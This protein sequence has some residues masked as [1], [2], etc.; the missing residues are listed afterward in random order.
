MENLR[1]VED[2]LREDNINVIHC[3]VP[4]KNWEHYDPVMCPR[5]IRE[6]IENNFPGVKIER[7]GG[8]GLNYHYDIQSE[9]DDELPEFGCTD[10]F[11]QPIFYVGFN[12]S[13]QVD[14]FVHAWTTPPLHT[15]EAPSDFHLV[16]AG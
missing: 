1:V 11:P 4:S 3:I 10:E 12:N 8:F 9:C 5:P 6:W 7:I 15:P 2:I 14:Q 13:D 16:N